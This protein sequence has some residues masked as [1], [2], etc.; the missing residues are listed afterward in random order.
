[1]RRASP[2]LAWFLAGL[3]VVL[4]VEKGLGVRYRT[5]ETGLSPDERCGLFVRDRPKSDDEEVLYLMVDVASGRIWCNSRQQT[6]HPPFTSDD[7]PPMRW[8]GPCLPVG[9]GP[10]TAGN[11]SSKR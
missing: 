10:T 9:L 4:L 6:R 5:L 8:G 3:G 1:M 2:S 11:Q 7:L